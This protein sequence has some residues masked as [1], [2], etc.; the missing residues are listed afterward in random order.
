MFE[1]LLFFLGPAM[2]LRPCK[3]CGRSTTKTCSV[4]KIPYCSVGCQKQDWSVHKKT[5]K[6]SSQQFEQVQAQNGR[7]IE[8]SSIVPVDSSSSK[9]SVGPSPCGSPQ[10]VPSSPANLEIN[11]NELKIENIEGFAQMFGFPVTHGMISS[12]SHSTS[13]LTS[14]DGHNEQ[15]ADL[16]AETPNITDEYKLGDQLPPENFRDVTRPDIT[17]GQQR[18]CPDVTSQIVRDSEMLHSAENLH[19]EPGFQQKS[20]ACVTNSVKTEEEQTMNN[21]PSGFLILGT[22][23]VDERSFWGQIINE[24]SAVELYNMI[25]ELTQHLLVPLSHNKQL[26]MVGNLCTAQFMEEYY[27][28]RIDKIHQDGTVDVTYIDYGNSERRP[29]MELYQLPTKFQSLPPQA[30]LFVLHNVKKAS[31]V[32]TKKAQFEFLGSMIVDKTLFAENKGFSSDKNVE[33]IVT[34][35]DCKNGLSVNAQLKTLFQSD[36]TEVPKT[37]ITQMKQTELESNR[38]GLSTLQPKGLEANISARDESLFPGVVLNQSPLNLIHHSGIQSK[39]TTVLT[40]HNQTVKVTYSGPTENVSNHKTASPTIFHIK[41]LPYEKVCQ[42]LLSVV[43]THVLHPSLFW[44]QVKNSELENARS[45]LSTELNS[46]YSSSVCEN[47]VPGNG[48]VCVAQFSGDG[49]WY[50]AVVDMVQNNGTLRVSFFDFG[51]SEDVT[52]ERIRRIEDQFVNLPRQAIKCS[53]HGVKSFSSVS[54]WSEEAM[55]WFNNRILNKECKMQVLSSHKEI[56][57]VEMHDALGENQAPSINSEFVSAGFGLARASSRSQYQTSA[58]SLGQTGLRQNMPGSCSRV[59]HTK[60]RRVHA[61]SSSTSST[62]SSSSVHQQL[63]HEE[64]SSRM[65]R[66]EVG[67]PLHKSKHNRTRS[68]NR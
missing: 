36:I 61:R 57:F 32:E 12:S 18:N 49:Q 23:V 26:F 25:N 2:K 3:V 38:T 44:V 67:N 63:Q 43:V 62:S 17:S 20:V 55:E 13:S 6:K 51:N 42:G 45:Q 29:S 24:S 30:K 65:P 27:R 46:I 34:C 22:T 1:T 66:D 68:V 60:Q 52:I 5:C 4:C 31:S 50:R 53:L 9:S 28:A 10:D 48:M 14:V 59:E 64:K 19:T 40:E 33:V 35:S 37:S 56:Q 39:N 8:P 15:I 54:E 11:E 47:Y 41:N 21:L 7:T 16:K 58:P